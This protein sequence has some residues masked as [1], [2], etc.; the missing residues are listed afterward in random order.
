MA[1]NVTW[2][3]FLSAHPNFGIEFKKAFEASPTLVLTT[4]L[5]PE[6]DA[7]QVIGS[8]MIALAGDF[9]SILTLCS[10]DR[11]WAAFR[12]LRSAFERAVT[13]KYIALNPAEALN[14]LDFDALD[15]EAVISGIEAKDIAY[16]LPDARD[17]LRERANAAKGRFRQDKC[18]QCGYRKQTTWTPHSAQTLSEKAGMSYMFLEAFAI[19]SK[20]IHPTHYGVR[21]ELSGSGSLMY[22]I[23]KHTHALAV[24]TILAHQLYF[25]GNRTASDLAKEALKGFF[26]V[27]LYSDTDFGV[28]DQVRLLQ[29]PR[30]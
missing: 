23:A 4:E 24:E 10:Y 14:F 12:L 20:H 27:W 30:A 1:D 15:W 17:V 16:M 9:D 2:S 3:Q 29:P 11:V 13:L 19:S 18:S 7:G 28:P 22:N 21:S 6:D 8:L 5:K 25:H 26:A